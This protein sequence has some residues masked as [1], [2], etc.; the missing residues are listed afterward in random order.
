MNK[1]KNIAA[2][3]LMV[4]ALGITSCGDD[5]LKEE[6]ITRRDLSYFDTPEGVRDMADGLPTIL[7]I[8]HSYEYSYAHTN[9]GTDEFALGSDPSNDMWNNYS[10]GLQ[11]VVSGSSGNRV[12][13]IIAWDMCYVAINNQNTVISKA[14]ASLEGQADLN[15]VLGSAYF[16]RGWTY[17]F[18][19]EQWGGVPL[20]L[21]PSIELEREFTRAT[22][23]A[24]IQQVIDDLQ[25]A[26]DLL[27]N[28]NIRTGAASKDAAAHFLAK[29]LLHRQSEI[30]SEFGGKTKDADLSKALQLCDEVIAHRPL[31][32]D[33]AELWDFSA[34]DG[35]NEKL[36]EMILAAQYTI[37][38]ANA[39]AGS[40]GNQMNMYYI[41]IYQNWAGMNRDRAGGREYA[42]LRTTDYA[43]DVYDRRNDSR[44]W[45]SFR[46]KQRLNIATDGKKPSWGTHLTFEVGQLGVLWIINDEADAE[47]FQVST[48]AVP[49]STTGKQPQQV[50][51]KNALN[52]YDTINCP[53]NQHDY[54]QRA[55]ALPRG[56]RQQHVHKG[57]PHQRP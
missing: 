9:Y 12:Q 35:D 2:I 55:A 25:K 43:M 27:G 20:K 3:A 38:T 11:S 32:A 13:P 48:S 22:L 46:T 5:F 53:N 37:P 17:L 16:F 42:R 28:D 40:Y 30:C 47:R 10:A 54:P 31:A 49:G 21:S 41:S 34:I 6:Q 4:C 50:W 52:I 36:P 44:F 19:V 56:H 14:P 1:I 45:K 7:R 39:A 8:K 15:A 51:Q 23:E 24:S 18:L 57:L 33:F 29:A 26:Y